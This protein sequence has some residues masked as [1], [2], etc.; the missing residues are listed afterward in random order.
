MAVCATQRRTLVIYSATN[1]TFVSN[2][3]ESTIT[4]PY[5]YGFS[6]LQVITKANWTIDAYD[7]T[8]I[9][10]NPMDENYTFFGTNLIVESIVG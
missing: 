4:F 3:S 2:L 9:L 6:D 10:G 5:G 7:P 1:D 8:L